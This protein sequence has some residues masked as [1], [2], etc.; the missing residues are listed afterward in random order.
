MSLHFDGITLGY[1]NRIVIKNFSAK[2]AS[3]SLIAIMGNNGSGK[4]T[5]LKAIAGLIK[6]LSGNIS[7]P[8]KKRIA[9]LSQQHA[10]DL[11]FPINVEALTRTGLWTFCGLWKS[12]RFYQDKIQNALEMV[13]LTALATRS[14]DTLSSGQLQRA[15]FARIILQDA[16]IILLDE[17]FNGVDY[18]TQKDLL[19]LITH[20]QQQGRTVLTA[21]HDALVVKKHFPQMIQMNKQN[22]FYG[23]TK[24]FFNDSARHIPSSCRSYSFQIKPLK[25]YLT[26]NTF[27]Y[28][29]S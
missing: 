18:R 4:S 22:A 20:W 7:S 29:G 17:P 27:N 3:G 14:L 15:L 8:P 16:D 2:L 5:L 23:E 13:G 10:I 24:Q 12:Q 25:K 11:T 6:P 26:T 9:Y 21:L 1:A 28:V 19:R